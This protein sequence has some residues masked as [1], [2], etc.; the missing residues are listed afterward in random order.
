[1]GALFSEKDADALLEL[2]NTLYGSHLKSEKIKVDGFTEPGFVELNLCLDRLDGSSR[3]S[4]DI[5]ASLTENAISEEEGRDLIVD[6]L[7]YYLGLFFKN[8]REPLLPL[9]FQPYPFGELVVYARGDVTCPKLDAMADEI[10]TEGK[11]L[12]PDDPRHRLKRL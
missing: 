5:R 2:L 10:I 4:I 12:S 7:G 6:F 9:D 8:S 1:M 11:P 3:Y